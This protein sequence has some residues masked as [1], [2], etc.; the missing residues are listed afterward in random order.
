PGEQ[1]P[2]KGAAAVGAQPFPLGAGEIGVEHA[3]GA[4]GEGPAAERLRPAAGRVAELAGEEADDRVGDV[5]LAGPVGE[6][7]RVRA[8]GDKVQREVSHDLAARGYL[9]D[10]AQDVVGGGVHVLDLLELLPE[11]QG[12]RL[13]TQVGQLAAGDLMAVDTA[14]R[15]GQ[16][17]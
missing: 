14:G 5:V 3:G 17:G 6:V 13:L 11:A 12:Y 15:R 2:V 10:A 16:A 7:R 8:D 4:P 1:E 9:D